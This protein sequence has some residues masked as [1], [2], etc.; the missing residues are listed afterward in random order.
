MYS[1]PER[2]DH[3]DRIR[4]VGKYTYYRILEAR[5]VYDAH[6]NNLGLAEFI[7]LP[8]PDG[9]GEFIIGLD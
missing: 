3:P 4:K 8:L 2:N 7:T 1:E 9:G 6:L 5:A